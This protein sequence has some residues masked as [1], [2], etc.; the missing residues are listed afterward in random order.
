MHLFSLLPSFAEFNTLVITVE[1]NRKTPLPLRIQGFL[2]I[3]REAAL[4]GNR[5]KTSIRIMEEAEENA[6]WVYV[7]N[8][9]IWRDEEGH[10]LKAGP[11]LL[12]MTNSLLVVARLA[13][14]TDRKDICRIMFTHLSMQTQTPNPDPKHFRCELQFASRNSSLHCD[15]VVCIDK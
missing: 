1:R 3:P 8:G 12:E 6:A 15:I 13:A 9:G 7:F 11:A 14:G 10:Q 5:R 4:G 2:A